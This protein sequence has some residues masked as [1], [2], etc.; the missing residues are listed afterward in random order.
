MKT[1]QNNNSNLVENIKSLKFQNSNLEET[2]KSIQHKNSNLEQTVLKSDEEMK[3]LKN[4]S[5]M[6]ELKLIE[7][8][9][10]IY[11]SNYKS[12]YTNSM[13]ALINQDLSKISSAMVKFDT[14]IHD[15]IQSF[16]AMMD[17]KN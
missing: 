5:N 8:Q 4:H 2:I 3:G 10:E 11:F 12:N 9:S 15:S 14:Q 1:I 6:Q 13:I 17:L 16:Q 7:Y